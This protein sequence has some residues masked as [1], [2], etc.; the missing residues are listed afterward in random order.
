MT[1]KQLGLIATALALL[2]SA[3]FFA[4]PYIAVYRAR[5]AAE[6]GD[7]ATVSSFVDF[8]ALRTSLKGELSA[9]MKEYMQGN[10]GLAAGLGAAFA[11]AFIDRII[12]A[13]ITPESV[14]LIVQGNKPSPAPAGHQAPSATEPT[15]TMGYEGFSSFVVDFAQPGDPAPF[16]IVLSRDGLGWKLTGVRL[17]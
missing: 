8:P 12:D 15:V 9:K 4:T 14:A 5:A 1:R 3:L 6:Q 16:G 2:N 10:D 13:M 7:S 17:P 11:G